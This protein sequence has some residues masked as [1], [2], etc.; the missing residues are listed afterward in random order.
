M[1]AQELREQRLEAARGCRHWTEL[2]PDRLT[3]TGPP[4]RGWVEDSES[5]VVYALSR[6]SVFVPGSPRIFATHTAVTFM[7]GPEGDV[8][9]LERIHETTRSRSGATT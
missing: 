1:T 7:V 2:P 8:V 4:S 3:P 5:G 9:P 6:G